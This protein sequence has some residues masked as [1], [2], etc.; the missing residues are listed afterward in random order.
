VNISERNGKS[1]IAR[2][3]VSTKKAQ[4]PSRFSSSEELPLARRSRE[5]SRAASARGRPA[6]P[7]ARRPM[8]R[9]RKDAAGSESRPGLDAHRAVEGGHCTP[10]PRN[11]R[12]QAAVTHRK[13]V[14]F[15]LE[16][17]DGTI[18]RAG[19]D[20]ALPCRR[21]SPATRHARALAH[22][23]RDLHST[24]LRSPAAASS[25]AAARAQH[26]EVEIDVYPVASARRRARAAC[27]PA[28]G[29]TSPPPNPPP[30]N[31]R[32]KSEKARAADVTP[33]L[34][35]RNPPRP[36]L[37]PRDRSADQSARAG[38]SAGASRSDS[39]SLA[40][41]ISLNRASAAC[42]SGSVRMVL[43]RELRTPP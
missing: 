8:P 38:R 24:P 25:R 41:L 16:A 34:R 2:T 29:L 13:V 35:T 31:V 26:L 15:A 30:K 33:R 39:T 20:A 43:A 22:A 12:R 42:C 28:E 19:R 21:P 40:S 9:S 11:G 17:G 6:A 27:A 37:R 7:R 4:R 10:P 1:Q 3:G 14:A 18:G 36:R 32:K 5:G 23:G